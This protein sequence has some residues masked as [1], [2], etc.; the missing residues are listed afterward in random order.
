LDEDVHGPDDHEEAPSEGRSDPES[1][2]DL[3]RHIGLLGYDRRAAA[4]FTHT[5]D[6]IRFGRVSVR[7][8]HCCVQRVNSAPPQAVNGPR[9]SAGTTTPPVVATPDAAARGGCHP[10]APWRP[11]RAAIV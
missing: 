3:G 11:R 5:D 7:V 8:W 6:R 10:R 4:V 1:R 9:R 2:G